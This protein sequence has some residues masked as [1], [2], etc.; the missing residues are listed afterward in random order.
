MKTKL[1]AIGTLGLLSVLSVGKSFYNV[2]A[3]DIADPTGW[4]FKY[5]HDSVSNRFE[6]TSQVLGSNGMR[7]AYTQPTSNAYTADYLSG[8]YLDPDLDETLTIG[9]RLELRQT[10]TSF[11]QDAS[12]WYPS[13]GE[14]LLG[15]NATTTPAQQKVKLVLQNP[16]NINYQVG[17]NI[18]DTTTT[19]N[20]T[21]T[22]EPS[23]N[24]S[25]GANPMSAS[26]LLITTNFVRSTTNIQMY[27]LP[28]YSKV[29]L[30]SPLSTANVYLRGFWIG[31]GTQPD[32]NTYTDGYEQGYDLGYDNGFL[33]GQDSAESNVTSRIGLLIQTVFGGLSNIFNIKIFDQL[34]LGTVMLFPMAFVIFSFIFRLI[35][36][37]RS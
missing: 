23:D 13:T 15:S 5:D 36:G 17:V 14:V 24:V 35:R 20:W 16:T 28:P 1:L 22:Y 26:G 2:N 21:L 31:Q 29:T 18:S 7:V 33:D 9:F 19:S 25:I 30:D 34:T 8:I 27:Y 3:I 32:T 11:T 12:F 10:T 6:Y 37:G 4:T